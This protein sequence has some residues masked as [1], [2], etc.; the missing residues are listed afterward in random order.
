MN[1]ALFKI[2][3]RLKKIRKN[4]KRTEWNK[5][6]KLGTKWRR[7][8]GRDN[9]I[10]RGLDGFKVRAGYGTPRKIKALHPRG[11]KEVIVHNL[12]ELKNVDKDVVVRI[13]SGVGL[14]NRVEMLKYA[15]EKGIHV[16]NASLKARMSKRMAKTENMKLKEE[17]RKKREKELKE[18]EK[19]EKENI[20]KE[21]SAKKDSDKSDDSMKKSETNVKKTAKSKA[22]SNSE[23]KTKN[24]KSSKSEKKGDLEKK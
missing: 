21:G 9:K 8:K 10:R 20:E 11:K 15:K 18:K 17:R 7:A 3:E 19:N 1:E 24:K 4:F 5:R 22:D 14:K 13:S 2:R 16:L 6:K 12:E 23:S